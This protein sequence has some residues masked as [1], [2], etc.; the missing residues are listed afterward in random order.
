M[1]NLLA[2]DYPP[3]QLEVVVACDASDD[4]TDEI[5]EEIAAR[6][7]RVSL[8]RAPREG[9]RPALDRAVRGTDSEL[10][11]FSARQRDLGAR[12]AAQARSQLR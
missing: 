1:E 10:V 9:K 4:R 2:L 5:V 3:E 8:L 11:A 7:P 6:E 12:C